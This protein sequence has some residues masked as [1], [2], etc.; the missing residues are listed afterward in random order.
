VPST[1]VDCTEN[2]VTLIRE[3]KGDISMLD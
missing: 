1:V 2:Q 3:G